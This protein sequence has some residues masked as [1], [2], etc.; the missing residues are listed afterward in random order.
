[1]R[2]LIAA[3]LIVPFGLAGCSPA[4]PEPEAVATE[5]GAPCNVEVTG[6]ALASLSGS[7]TVDASASGGSADCETASLSLVLYE[8]GGEAIYTF[9]APSDQLLGFGEVSGA[10]AMQAALESWAGGDWTGGLSTTADL[11]TWP[12]GTDWPEAGEFPF[13]VEDGIDQA[14]YERIR[15]AATLMYC[16]VQG[17]E[18]M[19]CLS[20]DESSVRKIGA[21][22][23]PG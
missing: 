20:V 14:A 18:S 19:A 7:Y 2:N 6:L 1:M 23:L 17:R 15:A 4:A 11:P 10:S 5:A 22:A 12:E 3:A 13:Y 8:A 21:Q 16:H 9:E